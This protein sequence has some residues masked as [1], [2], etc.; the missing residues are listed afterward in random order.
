[1]LT[2][3]AAIVFIFLCI[4]AAWAALGATVMTR[5]GNQD[6]SLKTAVGQL[7]GTQ[8]RQLAPQ[9]HYQTIRQTRVETA[10]GGKTVTETKYET[11]NHPLLL[12][13]SDIK[14]D[15]NLEYRQKGLLWYSTYR[16]RFDGKYRVTN[17]T[18][19]ESDISFDFSA[20]AQGGV[21]DNFRLVVGGKEIPNLPFNAGVLSHKIRLA[22]GQSETV[23]VGYGS[24]GMDEWWYDFGNEV[25]QVKNFSLAMRTDFDQIDYPQSSL[26]PRQRTQSAPA[27][28]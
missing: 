23:E 24:Q 13:G 21:Y 25:S 26:S 17:Y 9:V 10:Q 18:D 19:A 8:Q 4:A 1:M 28:S 14:V 16:V 3:M 22:P 7:W 2:R 12:D 27:G 6:E 15:L 11:I 20:P 5:T